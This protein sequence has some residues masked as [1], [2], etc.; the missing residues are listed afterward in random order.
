MFCFPPCS[1]GFFFPFL[2]H[3]ARVAEALWEHA[4][5]HLC[6]CVSKS[7]TAMDQYWVPGA[8]RTLRP[9]VSREQAMVYLLA[10][11]KDKPVIVNRVATLMKVMA[12]A[13]NTRTKLSGHGCF[14]FI[15][16]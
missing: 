10:L 14:F 9:A 2:N 15:I 4:A 8:G 3:S 12:A 7:E 13:A 6:V 11:A 1:Q 5:F 16:I